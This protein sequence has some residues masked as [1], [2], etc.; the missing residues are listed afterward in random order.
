MEPTLR[1]S[2]EPQKNE[3]VYG[4]L[5][6]REM[7]E[8]GWAPVRAGLVWVCFGCRSGDGKIMAGLCWRWS[9]ELEALGLSYPQS[10]ETGS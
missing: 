4:A 5:W 2:D 8:K 6:N 9:P 10:F 7:G 1:S 3:G